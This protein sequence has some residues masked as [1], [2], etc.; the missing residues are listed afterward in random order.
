[1]STDP[2]EKFSDLKFDRPAPQVLRIT[3]NRPEKRN[4]LTSAM[5]AQ[6]E[7]VWSVIDRDPSVR[8][9]ILTGAGRAFCAGG[10][11]EDMPE[12]GA[13]DTARQVASDFRGGAGL[14]KALLDARKP[15]VSAINGPA[16]GAGLALAL[17]SDIPIAAKQ[18]KLFDGHVNIGVA[19]GD[20][21][22]IIWPLLCGMAKS[23]YFLLTN[24][25]MTGEEAERNNLVALA[26]DAEQLEQKSIEVAA[27]IAGSAP[28]AIRITKH[29]LNHWLR[30]AQ[31]IFE[32]SL[33]LELIGFHGAE[34]TEA[35]AAQLERRPARFEKDSEF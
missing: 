5:H 28:T 33:A 22:A 13:A 4:A 6:I 1:M 20:H 11:V 3:L 27:K 7:E 16:V 17:L 14:V 2:Y 35:I 24:E 32:L 31:P 15:I 12:A 25:P 8:C 10:D 23:K 21:A 26:V 9:T 19:A 30:Q 29:V 18:A 34:S